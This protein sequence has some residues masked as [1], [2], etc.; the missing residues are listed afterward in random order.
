MRSVELFTGCGGLA[1]GLARAGFTHERMVEFN[2]CAVATI[3]H[4][5][6][7][8]LEHVKHWP[9]ELKDVREI[10]W[11]PHA[12]ASLVA[13]GPPCQPFSIGGKARGNGDSR[14]MWP[15]A[16]RAV[17][18]VAPSAFL[19][20]NVRGLMREKFAPYLTSIVDNL[21]KPG[22]RLTY[23]VKV[24]EVNA[25]DYGAAQKRHRVI[26]VGLRSD[27]NR[28]LPELE[29]THSRDRLLWDQ[30][31]TGEYWMRHGIRRDRESFDRID[32]GA[33]SRLRKRNQPPAH[34]P[35]VTVRDCLQGLG[36]P[37]GVNNH[38]FQPGAR[39]YKGHTG[40]PLDQPAKALKA[41]DHGVPGGENMMVM[42][43]GEVR[44]FTIREAARLQGLPDNYE[45]PRSWT[46]SMRQLGNAVPAELAEA[47]GGWMSSILSTD[48][49][50]V[51][52]AA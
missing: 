5:K 4:N 37:D 39:V 27:L 26:I 6:E 51:S 17:R 13:G 40:S 44:Y 42:D 50:T 22:A 31:V 2:G 48:G 43:N 28:E 46:E 11:K 15:Q 32:A 47:V 21:S 29:Q 33:V 19:F 45:F 49:G 7:L 10:D 16:I 23:G 38:V 24:R 18:E 34:K 1:L 8:G 14:D 25:A 41:G 12:G 36:E 52:I 3:E 20:E 30:W 9:I 35:W